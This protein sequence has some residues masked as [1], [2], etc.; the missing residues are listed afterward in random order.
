M[1]IAWVLSVLGLVVVAS[2]LVA[3]GMAAAGGL[4]VRVAIHNQRLLPG[5]AR[6]QEIASRM[7]LLADARGIV[8]S[9]FFQE[10]LTEWLTRLQPRQNRVLDASR[11][12]SST[13]TPFFWLLTHNVRLSILFD[14]DARHTSQARVMGELYRCFLA[15]GPLPPY[16][17][18]A[19]RQAPKDTH[20][21]P[22]RCVVAR[23]TRSRD[24]SP[25]RAVS[26]PRVFKYSG[27]G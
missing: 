13:L 4:R 3:E 16:A 10:G 24:G 12:I 6:W 5:V 11:G 26:K 1:G 21:K 19:K 2:S 27:R 14:A 15:S 25:R 8:T 20:Q 9:R 18:S 23:S 22:G 17:P 7:A